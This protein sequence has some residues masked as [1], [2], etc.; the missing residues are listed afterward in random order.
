MPQASSF[1]FNPVQGGV[2]RMYH[3][4]DNM[5]DG[6]EP[7][8]LEMEAGDTVFFHPLLIHGSGAN[9]TKGF[10]KVVHT[11]LIMCSDIVHSRFIQ[12]SNV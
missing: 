6:M 7:T 3:G 12:W 8:Y 11:C 1:P 5:P 4:I 9:K 2:N 10:R